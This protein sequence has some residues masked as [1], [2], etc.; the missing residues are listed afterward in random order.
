[1][2]EEVNCEFHLDEEELAAL[3]RKYIDNPAKTRSN[4]PGKDTSQQSEVLNPL[5]SS[6][7]SKLTLDLPEV[8]RQKIKREQ[9]REEELNR[10]IELYQ[11][12]IEDQRTERKKLGGIN[13]AQ[14][15]QKQL[16][17]QVK[18]L[19]NRL[20][21]ANQKFNQ[22]VARNKHLRDEIDKLRKEKNIYEATYKKLQSELEEKKEEMD[23]ALESASK[24]YENRQKAIQQLE[25]LKEK[26]EREQE[27]YETEWN[28]LL[29]Q[30]E[31]EKKKKEFIQQREK[32]KIT[33]A[34]VAEID[35]EDEQ[36]IR[37]LARL[38]EA[39]KTST[40]A[41][42][43]MVKSYEEALE[44]IKQETG[45]ESLDQLVEAFVRYEEKNSALLKF[46][47]EL[48][49]EIEKVERDIE[50]TKQQIE[51]YKEMGA[52]TDTEK[53][54]TLIQLEK[55]LASMEFKNTINEQRK[56]ESMK[57]I[58]FIKEQLKLFLQT[59]GAEEP[60]LAEMD[61]QGLTEDNMMKYLSEI[62]LRAN[63]IIQS[64]A[65]IQAQ[66]LQID[67]I[68]KDDPTLHRANIAAL[69]NVMALGSQTTPST[70]QVRID[71]PTVRNT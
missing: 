44:K 32:D 14:E 60:L 38:A 70:A 20:D 12:K 29:G 11:Q 58:A 25:E 62:E 27:Q 59:L 5:L 15:N 10:Q 41:S 43:D 36:K 18:I 6:S 48:S 53:K 7:T 42:L 69:N 51:K 39:E 52:V 24:A 16:A 22:A 26:N 9:E 71:P 1:M 54:Q 56:K 34:N 33:E 4:R 65:L 46:V 31:Q 49:E 63:K 40:T 30:I 55:K 28:E 61:Q 8:L 3:R 47:N 19:E 45:V 66:K 2:V 67:S 68:L 21:K 57:T 35:P 23:T 50:E 64:Y 37:N 17:K 13:A